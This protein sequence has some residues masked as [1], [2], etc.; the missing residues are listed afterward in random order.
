MNK[1]SIFVANKTALGIEFGSTR[2]KAVLVDENNNVLATG[3]HTW[4]NK[5]ENGIWTYSLE[6]IWGGVQNAYQSLVKKVEENFGVDISTFGAIGISGMMHGYFALDKNGN[7]LSP[8]RTWRNNIASEAADYLTE[9]FD[10]PI[11][12]RWSIA[13]LYEAITSGKESVDKID[14]L[15]TLAGYVHY[16]LTG[17]HTMGIGEASGMFP[18]D[19]DTKN[20]D[21]KFL[22]VFDGLV[23]KYNLPWKL[24]DILPTIKMVGQVSGVLTDDGAKLLDV[25]EK[26]ASGIKVCPPE[27]DAGTGMVA[28][29][30]VGKRT[31]NVSCG[32]S[33]FGMIVLDEKL[34]KTYNGVDLVTTPAGDLVAMVHCNNCSSDVNEWTNL[35]AEVAELCGAEIDKGELYTR[36]FKKALEGEDNASGVLVYNYVSGENLTEVTN[37][38]PMVV[39]T[40]ESKMNLSNFM[41]AQVYSTFITLKLGFNMLS[42]HEKVKIDKIV[43]H[44]GLFMTKGVCQNFLAS[45]LK[46]PVTVMENASEGGAWG[47]A[48]L[49]NYM[50]NSEDTFENYLNKIF[51]KVESIVV[52]PN[53]AQVVGIDEYM[54]NFNKALCVEQ[55]A[56]EVL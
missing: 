23:E 5:L 24:I 41:R 43:G 13:H 15:T 1:E 52:A 28:T 35:F 32:T 37:G 46:A 19:V 22:C 36:L 4:E 42:E 6:D 55:K 29:N 25:S 7:L 38:R 40:T 54:N 50:N 30:S 8:F 33:I 44:G 20:Y 17:E 9:Q 56:G 27:G 31:C 21:Q 45:A 12:A 26:L 51:D 16:K 49:A 3:G 18:I 47:I 14:H 10:Y 2:I 11:P 48:V 39:R 53:E 34:K